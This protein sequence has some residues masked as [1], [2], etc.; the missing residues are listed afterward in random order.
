MSLNKTFPY[1][2][3]SI[4]VYL[5]YSCF[6]NSDTINTLVILFYYDV[7]DFYYSG[8]FIYHI[9]VKYL[10]IKIIALYRV[11]KVYYR[12]DNTIYS[13]TNTFYSEIV[14]SSLSDWWHFSFID[15]LK[16]S[17]KCFIIN[18]C[19]TCLVLNV[20]IV[21]SVCGIVHIKDPLLLIKKVAH[22]ASAGFF[23]HY[24][25][26]PRSYVWRRYNHY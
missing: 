8:Y 14:I 26:G 3:S 25:N 15:N 21:Y 5:V 12:G 16:Y 1:F 2:L 19:F 20:L 13:D 4:Y 11:N 23:S 18:I 24:R 10:Y 22:V 9:R 6:L 7:I 17:T